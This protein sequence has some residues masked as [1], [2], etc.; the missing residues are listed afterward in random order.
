[1][2]L[3]GLSAMTIIENFEMLNFKNKSIQFEHYFKIHKQT[4]KIFLMCLDLELFLNALSAFKNK[5]VSIFEVLILKPV[6]IFH[7]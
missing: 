3:S 4:S 2:L 6:Q 5:L 1:V 7:N